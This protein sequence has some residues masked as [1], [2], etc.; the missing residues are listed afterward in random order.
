MA[1]DSARLISPGALLDAIRTLSSDEFEGRAPGSRGEDR[2]VP[3]IEKRFQGLGLE[4][5]NP[6]GSYLQQVDLVGVT[7]DPRMRL[8]LS[9]AAPHGRSHAAI[10]AR[11]SEQFVAWTK[12]FVRS[13]S[14]DA[15]MV[16]AG[17]GVQAPEFDWDDFK[18][19]DVRGK[20]LV[21]LINDPPV[22]DDRVFGGKAMT[23][24][25]RWTYKFEKATELGAAGCLI[26]HD[27]DAAGYGWDVVTASF[28][29]EQFD[30][31]NPDGNRGRLAV[32][33]W[34][35]GELTADLFRRAGLDLA[36][37]RAEAATRDFRPVALGMRG[38]LRIDNRLRAVHSRNVVA[39]RTGSDL[40]LRDEY[41][42]YTAHWDHFGIG[43]EVNGDRIYHGA[44]DNASGVAAMLEVARAFAALPVAPRR[45]VLFLAVTAEEQGLLGS[46]YYAEHPLYPLERTAAVLNRDGMNVHGRTRDLVSIGLGSSTL[47]QVVEDVA[48]T[49]GRVVTADPEPEKGAFY[50][51]DH[52]SFVKHGV[53]AFDPQ[54]GVDYP[55]RPAGFGIAMRRRYTA[56]DYHKPSDK[57]K[58][59]WD[60]GGA[61]EDCELAFLVG[62]RVA[63]ADR[64]PEWRPGA[65]FGRPREGATAGQA[66]AGARDPR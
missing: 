41:V 17:Y 16:F 9:P 46:R 5:G 60:L 14:V 12:R 58:D 13:S 36:Q 22:A 49:Q 55:G 45:T 40:R 38:H 30:L 26:V 1:A 54:S 29:A 43:R 63:Q 39:K 56:E 4:P 50:R 18:G 2:T 10:E 37:L 19:V 20:L 7:P 31:A 52:F 24:Y 32:E 21:V 62:W 11:F 59:D 47:D 6:D 44:I 34:I 51:S 61:I 25:G 48:R 8:A 66:G 33:G 42:V 35:T 27:A 28:G 64:M 23:Y 3:Y 53:P 65:E 57:I 15:E